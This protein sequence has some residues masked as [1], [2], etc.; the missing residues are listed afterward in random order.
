MPA[1]GLEEASLPAGF[2]PK[3]V[4]RYHDGQ[5]SGNRSEFQLCFL[6]TVEPFLAYPVSQHLFTWMLGVKDVGEHC[7]A[8][9]VA[10]S[11]AHNVFIKYTGSLVPLGPVTLAI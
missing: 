5:G 4:S 7:Q 3:P 10:M 1:G 8:V 11:K 2:S 9:R 6:S